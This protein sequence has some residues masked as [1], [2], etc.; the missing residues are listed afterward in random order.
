MRSDSLLLYESRR[1]GLLRAVSVV[2]CLPT[3]IAAWLIP[4]APRAEW[5]QA[6]LGGVAWWL[7]PA[8]LGL[9]TLVL[10]ASLFLLHG[11]Y[12]L[13]LDLDPDDQ[14][15]LTTFLLWGRRTRRCRPEEFNADAFIIDRQGYA[16]HGLEAACDPAATEWL[17]GPVKPTRF[18]AR[19][20]QN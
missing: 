1:E 5:A 9:F 16:P 17:A 2:C 11:R 14:L 8:A 15:T 18:T 6:P 4:L 20:I 7:L 3:I 12:V 19:R 10:P 13:R